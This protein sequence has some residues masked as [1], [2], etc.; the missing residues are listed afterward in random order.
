[1]PF[2]WDDS[3][4]PCVDPYGRRINGD[5]VAE[6][7]RRTAVDDPSFGGRDDAVGDWRDVALSLAAPGRR[8]GTGRHD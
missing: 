8:T 5:V 4:A 1:M 2:P 6:R 3:P 7:R